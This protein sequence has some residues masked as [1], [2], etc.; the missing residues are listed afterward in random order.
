MKTR[1]RLERLDLELLRSEKLHLHEASALLAV[2]EMTIRRDLRRRQ[3]G[4]PILVG[5]YVVSDPARREHKSYLVTEAGGKNKNLKKTI[6][7]Y[8]AGM[9]RPGQTV[10][11][12]C[13]STTEEIAHLL[14][15]DL[16]V[17]VLCNSLNICLALSH[18]RNCKVYLSG[19]EFNPDNLLFSQCGDTLMDNFRPDIAFVS[20]AGAHPEYGVTCHNMSEVNDKR[21]A[22]K[23]SQYRVLVCD[24]SKI[25]QSTAAYIAEIEAFDA[26]VTDKQIDQNT[27]KILADYL[28]LLLV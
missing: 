10:F 4:D 16:G 24:S 3:P 6:A 18:K 8:C 21:K 20:A 25:N 1:E 12:D 11:L 27:S 15:D 13:G 26:L 19:G 22:I 23:N 9:I 17:T 5:G 7:V 2:S 14:P 28:E